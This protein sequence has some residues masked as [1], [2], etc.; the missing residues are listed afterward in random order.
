SSLA[1]RH[2]C[3]GQSKSS[4]TLVCTFCNASPKGPWQ[5]PSRLV[6]SPAK[7]FFMS[8][9]DRD[10]QISDPLSQSCR[11]RVRDPTGFPLVRDLHLWSDAGCCLLLSISCTSASYRTSN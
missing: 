1:S 7:K 9:E 6:G 5:F 2:H 4:L 11:L 3:A 10:Q 8:L